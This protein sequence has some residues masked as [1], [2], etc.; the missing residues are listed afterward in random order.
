MTPLPPADA[1]PSFAAWETWLAGVAL[2]VLIIG[3][4]LGPGS[5]L[6]LDLLVTPKIPVPNGIFGLGPQLSQRTPFFVVFGVGSWLVGGPLITKVLLVALLAVG[7]VG[8]VRLVGSGIGRLPGIA[9]GVLWVAG[10]FAV[11]RIGVGHLTYVWLI[12]VLPWV[13]RHLIHPSADWRR[14][15]LAALVMAFG[16]PAVGV[17]SLVVLMAG[18]AAEPRSDRRVA[19]GMAIGG[20]TSLLWLGPTMVLWWAGANVGGASDFSTSAHGVDGW[21]GLLVGGGFW[22]DLQQVGGIGWIGAIGGLVIGLLALAGHHDLPDWTK[23]LR[24][25]AAVG[26]FVTVAS[27]LPVVREGYGWLTSLAVGAPLRE[28]QRFLVLWLLWAVPS[29]ALGG[30]RLALRLADADQP[31]SRTLSHVVAA[32]PLAVAVAVALPGLWGIDGRLRPVDFPAGWAEARDLVRSRPGPT[33]VL[34]WNEYPPLSFVGGRHVLNPLPDYLGGDVISSYDPLFDPA[35]PRQE[36]VDRRSWVVDDLLANVTGGDGLIG[37]ELADLGIRWVVLV[38]EEGWG[39]YA[40]LDSDPDLTV[41]LDHPDVVVYEVDGWAAMVESP[42]PGSFRFDRPLPPLILTD[43][44]PA[45]VLNVAGAP[46]WVRGWFGA[47][48]VTDD[49][50]LRLGEGTGGAVWFWPAPVLFAI[51]ILLAVVALRVIRGIQ[52]E[53][54]PR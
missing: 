9:A 19:R 27:A 21:L 28:S 50:R 7:Y 37:D 1:A 2:A 14:T 29:A 5:L 53:R 17:V 36:Q 48:D 8:M 41:A 13:V 33:V 42:V 3:P 18:L 52:A 32:V 40:R 31:F 30:R 51:D 16:G 34:P 49:G 4:G 35:H 6:N 25:T 39:R 26:L 43:A 54:W 15:F 44:P 38:R 45:S 20:A 12:A 47:V 24:W 23:P 11:T 10:P 22:S 46:G